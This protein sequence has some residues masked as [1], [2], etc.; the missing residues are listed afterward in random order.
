MSTKNTRA[1]KTEE[2]V[3]ETT[4]RELSKVEKF[5]IDENLDLDA[6]VLAEDLGVDVALVEGYLD[7]FEQT[8][9]S[10]FERALA[11]KQHGNAGVVIMTENASQRIDENYANIKKDAPSYVFKP[12]NARKRRT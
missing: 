5:Y 9:P 2:A 10:D 8:R 1:K 3:E 6:D 11:K 7:E 12:K 4:P